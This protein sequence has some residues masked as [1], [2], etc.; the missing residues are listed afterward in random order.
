MRERS[1][2]YGYMHE[3]HRIIYLNIICVQQR[4][5]VIMVCASYIAGHQVLFCVLGGFPATTR[6]RFVSRMLNAGG[7]AVAGARDAVRW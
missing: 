7:E 4:L 3:Y 5:S 6:L 1:V 2:L